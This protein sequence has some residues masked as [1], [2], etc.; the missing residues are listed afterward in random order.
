[1]LPRFSKLPGSLAQ[2]ARILRLD[3]GNI[4]A[5]LIH[6]DWSTPA[7]CV[8]WFH[9]RTAHKELDPGRYQRWL[10]AGI[11][12]CAIDLPGHGER[13]SQE[14]QVAGRSLEVIEQAV[15][16]VDR[17]LA[18]LGDPAFANAFD[19]RR[20]GIGGMS[21]GGMVV[22]RRLCDPHPFVAAAVEGTSGSLTT[23][24]SYKDRLESPALQRLNPILHIEGWRPI[25]LLALHSELDAIV[26]VSGMREFI[27]RLITQYRLHGADPA[28]VQLTTWPET[29]APQEHLGFG[30]V[31]GDAKNVQTAFFQEHLLSPPV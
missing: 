20:L 22:L 15:Q 6:P 17:I 30:R 3:N 14:L 16:E 8:L 24:P 29:G 5:L 9:G 27:D 31:A 25:R 10:R 18:A 4:P 11:A 12:T 23:L 19:R 26:P 7:P 21:A 2:H 1:M 28:L 13:A